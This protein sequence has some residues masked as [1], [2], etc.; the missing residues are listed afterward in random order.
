MEKTYTLNLRSVV[1]QLYLN[2]AVGKKIKKKKKGNNKN[3][4]PW[5]LPRWSSG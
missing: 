1:C 3:Q 4:K 2:K 5:R